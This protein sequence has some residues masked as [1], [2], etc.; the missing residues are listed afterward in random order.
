MTVVIDPEYITDKMS[1]TYI[2]D[3][4]LNG[5]GIPDSQES[6]IRLYWTGRYLNGNQT[7]LRSEVITGRAGLPVSLSHRDS[8]I[9]DTASPP[10]KWIYNGAPGQT[11]TFGTDA[12]A[13]FLY[14]YDTR[15]AGMPDKDQYINVG[16]RDQK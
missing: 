11:V 1:V 5:N 10:A 7:Q 16:T 4:D 12:S 9:N 2:Y 14:D 8:V 15:G 13:T 6:Q 3:T